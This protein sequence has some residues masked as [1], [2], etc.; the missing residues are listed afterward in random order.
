M[1]SE[2]HFH[3]VPKRLNKRA[4]AATTKDDIEKYILGF[5][6]LGWSTKRV[7]NE[8]RKEG[9]TGGRRAFSEKEM[10]EAIQRFKNVG[11]VDQNGCITEEGLIIS[12]IT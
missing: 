1:A 5:L 11:L 8:L 9:V 2:S 7:T 4:P 6:S 10:T 12:R 3:N